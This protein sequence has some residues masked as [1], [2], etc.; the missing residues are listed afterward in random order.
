MAN[1]KMPSWFP[2]A[3]AIAEHKDRK[4]N[5]PWYGRLLHLLISWRCPCCKAA[6]ET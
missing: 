6:R 3:L 4:R 2:K 5:W 1:F